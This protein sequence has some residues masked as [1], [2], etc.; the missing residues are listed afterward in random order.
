MKQAIAIT[1]EQAFMAIEQGEFGEDVTASGDAVV[2]VM[3]QDWCSQWT[4]MK[5]WIYEMAEGIDLYELIYNKVEYF[6]EFRRFKET[7]W[8]NGQIPYLRYY[9]G[10]N[11]VRE[12]NYV[13]RE[14]FIKNAGLQQS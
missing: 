11:L 2:V 4:S 12:S 6:D 9:R 14:E 10:G 1:R 8:R 5:N 7:K 13:S 3:T